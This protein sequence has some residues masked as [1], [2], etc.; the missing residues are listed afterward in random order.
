[1]PDWATALTAHVEGRLG[2]PYLAITLTGDV[3][4]GIGGRVG[5]AGLHVNQVW[6]EPGWPN[7]YSLLQCPLMWMR[8]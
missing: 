4:T 2:F 8:A 5:W 1:M 3:R 7:D 6:G